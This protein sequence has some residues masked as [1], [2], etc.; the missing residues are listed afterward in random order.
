MALERK[1]KN[2]VV[3]IPSIIPGNRA[4]LRHRKIENVDLTE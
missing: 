3:L 4:I 2:A 1:R